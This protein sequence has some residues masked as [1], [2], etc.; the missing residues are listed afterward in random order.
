MNVMA[1][2]DTLFIIQ[3]YPIKLLETKVLPIPVSEFW[4]KY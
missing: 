4:A 2:L 1:I 3:Q